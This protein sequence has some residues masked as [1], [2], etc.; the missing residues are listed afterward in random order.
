[1]WKC[2]KSIYD[3]HILICPDLY[4]SHN[5]IIEINGTCYNIT[6]ICDD[7][8]VYM[9]DDNNTQQIYP[10]PAFVQMLQSS[11]FKYIRNSHAENIKKNKLQSLS[12]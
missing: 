6:G 12:S 10:V 5:D 2:L 9:Q 1:M 7:Y 3:N 11:D 8:N 4:I